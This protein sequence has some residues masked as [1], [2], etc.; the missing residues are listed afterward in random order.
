MPPRRRRAPARR[1]APC[2][3]RA[4]VVAVPVTSGYYSRRS[5]RYR[6][7]TGGKFKDTMKK[8]GKTALEVVKIVPRV[9]GIN[10]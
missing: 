8:I 5:R 10:I 4:C 9:M 6:R 2:R 3:R 7:R 1:R